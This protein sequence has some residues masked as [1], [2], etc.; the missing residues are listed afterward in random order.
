[1]KKL[2]WNKK[3]NEYQDDTGTF[4]IISQKSFVIAQSQKGYKIKIN[5]KL[6]EDSYK[7]LTDAKKA[8]QKLFENNHIKSTF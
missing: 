4:R 6:I 1:M 3:A 8:C 5:G 7:K 2:H